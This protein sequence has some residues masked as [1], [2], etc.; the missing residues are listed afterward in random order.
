MSLPP[1]SAASSYDTTGVCRCP[2]VNLAPVSHISAGRLGSKVSASVVSLQNDRPCASTLLVIRGLA[3]R[4]ATRAS[5]LPSALR[6]GRQHGQRSLR[7]EA[8]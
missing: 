3:G 6:D 1:F 5:L 7:A 4:Y 8:N 2:P